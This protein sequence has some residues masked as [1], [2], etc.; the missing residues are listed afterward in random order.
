MHADPLFRK[1][2]GENKSILGTRTMQYSYLCPLLKVTKDHWARG[3]VSYSRTSKAR[4][5]GG[6]E[7]GE[8]ERRENAGQPFHSWQ[9]PHAKQVSFIMCFLKSHA[10]MDNTLQF[11]FW[12]H[13]LNSNYKKKHLKKKKTKHNPARRRSPSLSM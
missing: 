2:F 5:K 1:I 6:E 12:H 4:E 10:S 9:K 13:I 8:G 3:Q 7:E 11:Q